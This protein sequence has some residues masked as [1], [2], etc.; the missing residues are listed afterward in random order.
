VRVFLA[1]ASGV[2]GI[3]IVPLLV[4]ARHEVAAMTRSPDKAESLRL[5]GAEPVVCDVYD[6]DQLTIEVAAFRPEVVMHQLTDLPDDPSRIRELGAANSRIRREGTRN[7]IAAAQAAGA[8]RFV[9]Q[10]IAWGTDHAAIIDLER[11]VLD[12]HGIVLRYGQFYG[13]G[14]YFEDTK[15]PPPRIQIDDAANRTVTALDADPGVVTI[16][17]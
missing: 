1:G 9:A 2:I 3:R 7:L 8:T 16:L 4:S 11:A 13:P 17:E 14:T 12:I 5:L 15:P 6:A 10:S